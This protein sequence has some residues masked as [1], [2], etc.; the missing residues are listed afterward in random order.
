M[1]SR[2]THTQAL[3][4]CA[5]GWCG[6]MPDS[7]PCPELCESSREVAPEASSCSHSPSAG[8]GGCSFV[9]CSFVSPPG[10]CRCLARH[11]ARTTPAVVMQERTRCYLRSTRALQACD[12]GIEAISALEGAGAALGQHGLT[13]ASSPC[14]EEMLDSTS[15]CCGFSYSPLKFTIAPTGE[16]HLAPT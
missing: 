6:R 12:N 2:K 7:A 5:F 9:I 15:T 3:P 8:A 16:R 11:Q 13:S 1:T 14:W 4:T 10:L